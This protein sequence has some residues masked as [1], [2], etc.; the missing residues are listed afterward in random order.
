MRGL[1]LGLIMVVA[2]SS[3]W[4]ATK[5]KP[6][7]EPKISYQLLLSKRDYVA[8]LVAARK[9]HEE[10]LAQ[11]TGLAEVSPSANMLLRTEGTR[12]VLQ[13]RA[14][15]A[16]PNNDA[17]YALWDKARSLGYD[18]RINTKTLPT[19]GKCAS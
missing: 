14:S 11:M 5:A 10:M 15:Y 8:D 17:A 9:L 3:V 13:A 12:M 7:C 4:A 1:F 19:R 16:L 2:A 18:V 6:S